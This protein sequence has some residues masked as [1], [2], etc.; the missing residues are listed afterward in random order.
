MLIPSP[1]KKKRWIFLSRA[2]TNSQG[3][4]TIEFLLTFLFVGGFI[5]AFFKIAMIYTN[6][7]YIHYATYSAS[8]AYMVFDNNSNTPDGADSKASTF[9]KKVFESFKISALL[10]TSSPLQ[11]EVHD[12]SNFQG[13]EKNLYVGLFVDF[14]EKLLTPLL[15]K[16][17]ILNLRSESFLGREPTRAECYERIRWAMGGT[18][19]T[20]NQPFIEKHS[21]LFDNGC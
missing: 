11:V 14:K 16:G 8:R 19:G 2:F 6:G 9:A 15:G 12:P 18:A 17:R 13:H 3:Q 4:S 1:E 10:N 21:T 20:P 7:H 5:F